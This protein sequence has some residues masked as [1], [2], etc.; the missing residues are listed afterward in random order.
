[1]IQ[2]L[3]LRFSAYTVLVVNFKLCLL[4]VCM[5]QTYLLIPFEVTLIPKKKE[6]KV[7]TNGHS[8]LSFV[9]SN[10]KMQESTKID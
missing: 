10:Q 1:M 7:S 3:L 9:V 6:K 2:M 5:G 8:M 4:L